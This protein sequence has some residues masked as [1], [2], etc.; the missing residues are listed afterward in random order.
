MKKTLFLISL[1]VVVLCATPL[2]A[3]EQVDI[4][5]IENSFVMGYEVSTGNVDQTQRFG[6]NFN[7]TESLDAG[8]MFQQNSVGNPYNAGSYLLLRY[9]ALDRAELTL[10]YGR[11]TTGATAAAGVQASY[12][13]LRNDVQDISTVL[14][15]DMEYLL[16]NI[17]AAVDTGIF[18]VS[19]SLGFGI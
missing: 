2:V 12:E 5:E 10:M 11:D 16:Q 6:L 17:G 15:V 14:S 1:L 19:L 18:G 3:Q 13:L 7:L 8:F 9:K 4:L